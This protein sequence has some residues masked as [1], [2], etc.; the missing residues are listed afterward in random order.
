MS[1][2]IRQ[3][4][5]ISGWWETNDYMKNENKN[6]RTLKTVNMATRVIEALAEMD[7]AGV[8]ELSERFDISKSTIHSQLKTLQKNG[9][10]IQKEGQY[11]LSHK[12][13]QIGEYVKQRNLLYQAGKEEIDNIAEKTGH[14]CHLVIEERGTG[15]NLY[16]SKGESAVG[17]GYQAAKSQQ[18]DPLHVTASGKAILSQLDRER[19]ESIIEQHGLSERTD[20]TTT[21][22]E[23]LFNEL[24]QIREEGVAYND[25]EEIEGFRAVG[26]PICTRHGDVLGSVSISGPVSF[27]QEETFR[28]EIPDLA[29]KTANLIE[30]NINMSD[31][32]VELV[33]DTK[34]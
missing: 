26:V 31:R 21:D 20:Q 17:D 34:S 29:I 15:V 30:V 11:L 4:K 10:I 2:K 27:L 12:F 22:P 32:S 5:V 3:K 28:S 9:F 7:S 25:E 16:K 6:S 33:N 8:T 24:E 14:Y 23:Q 18:P 1:Q 19:V 13:L